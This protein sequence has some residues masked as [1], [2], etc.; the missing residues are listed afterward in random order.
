MIVEMIFQCV[1]I[2]VMIGVYGGFHEVVSDMARKKDVGSRAAAAAIVIGVFIPMALMGYS[3][4]KVIWG[5]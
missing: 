2:G 4:T 1:L 5:L 3:L